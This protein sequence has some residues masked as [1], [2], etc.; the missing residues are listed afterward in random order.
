MQFVM[1]IHDERKI[2]IKIIMIR[3]NMNMFFESISILSETKYS[4]KK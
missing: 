1:E 3:L 2:K 4:I